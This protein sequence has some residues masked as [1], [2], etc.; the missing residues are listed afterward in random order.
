VQ[1]YVLSRPLPAAEALTQAVML[2]KKLALI[3]HSAKTKRA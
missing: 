1:G 2:E 3:T